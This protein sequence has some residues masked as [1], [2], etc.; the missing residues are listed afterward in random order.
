MEVLMLDKPRHEMEVDLIGLFGYG[1]L[2]FISHIINDRNCL[3]DSYKVQQIIFFTFETVILCNNFPHFQACNQMIVS[4]KSACKR[5]QTAQQQEQEDP[6][7][8]RAKH[9]TLFQNDS[10]D[11][12]ST[13]FTPTQQPKRMLRCRFVKNPRINAAPW[14]LDEHKYTYRRRNKDRT[15][16]YTYYYCTERWKEC[17]KAT[18]I[19]V[20]VNEGYIKRGG[21]KH[22]HDPNPAKLRAVLHEATV[23][24]N[25]INSGST[26]QRRPRNALVKILRDLSNDKAEASLQYVSSKEAIRG[27]IRRGTLKKEKSS[28]QKIPTTWEELQNHGIPEMF[29]KLAN[30]SDFLR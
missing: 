1:N 10:D 14:L 2:S 19:Y 17:C 12:D 6:P 21:H 5:P 18:V 24:E 28:Q 30:G 26:Q 3:L 13:S 7:Q 20:K 4:D 29:T 27:R 8:K 15:G 23:V 11:D 9:R 25:A 16:V 22:N